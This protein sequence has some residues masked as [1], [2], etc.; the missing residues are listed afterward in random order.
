MLLPVFSEQLKG[1]QEKGFRAWFYA[2][3]CE[4]VDAFKLS[5]N[6]VFLYI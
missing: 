4:E 2:D 6:Y 5:V 1:I 3:K